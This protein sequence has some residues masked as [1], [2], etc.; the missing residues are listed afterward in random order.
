MVRTLDLNTAGVLY[1]SLQI[2][3]EHLAQASR[4]VAPGTLTLKV[5]ALLPGALRRGLIGELIVS[6]S[7]PRIGCYSSK[8]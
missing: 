3:S 8:L 6:M 2:A 4:R 5:V 7:L 1:S